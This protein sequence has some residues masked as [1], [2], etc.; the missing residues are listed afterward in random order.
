MA[1]KSVRHLAAFVS[2]PKRRKSP[3]SIRYHGVMLALSKA[4]A[5]ASV[6]GDL[7]E[8]APLS[9]NLVDALQAGPPRRR[10]SGSK[11]VVGEA[12]VV[13]LNEAEMAFWKEHGSAKAGA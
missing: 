3:D 2:P 6:L 10:A 4:K 12:L 11:S 7:G 1:K 8:T 9:N 5:M 13:A